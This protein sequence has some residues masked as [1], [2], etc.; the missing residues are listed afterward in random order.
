MAQ[1]GMRE[2]LYELIHLQGSGAPHMENPDWSSEPQPTLHC[3][4]VSRCFQGGLYY[5]KRR[6]NAFMLAI[7]S[8]EIHLHI[9]IILPRYLVNNC[10]SDGQHGTAPSL[11]FKEHITFKHP[12]TV[13]DQAFPIYAGTLLLQST[14]ILQINAPADV[15]FAR[16]SFYTQLS[17]SDFPSSQPLCPSAQASS[18]QL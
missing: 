9:V 2:R 12:I 17:R 16:V 10:T 4:C 15:K 13:T 14:R 11:Q 5:F 18:L 3:L 7:V 8:H 1:H 6:N